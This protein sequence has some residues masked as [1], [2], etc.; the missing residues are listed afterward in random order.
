MK[1]ILVSSSN[2]HSVGYDESNEVLEIQFR[3]GGVYQYY[4]VPRAV[5][6]GLMSASSHGKYFHTYIKKVYRYQCVG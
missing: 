3:S 4:G 1:R 5:Y 6:E 2:L